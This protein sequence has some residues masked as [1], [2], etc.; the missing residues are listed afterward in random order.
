MTRIGEHQNYIWQKLKSASLPIV[1][2]GM[3]NGCDK[4]LKACKTHHI[5]VS[6]IFASDDFVRAQRFHDFTVKTYNELL[7]ELGDFIIIIAFS[8]F[9]PALLERIKSLCL[10]HEVYA[11]DFSVFSDEYPTPSFMDENNLAISRAYSLLSDDRSRQIF[12]ILMKYK[13]TGKASLLFLCHDDAEAPFS[14]FMKLTENERYMD[15]GAYKGDTI[16]SFLRMTKGSFNVIHAFEPDPKNYAG[17][18]KY[19]EELEYKNVFIHECAVSDHSGKT[20]FQG[21]GGRA[22]H[23]SSEGYPV[24]CLRLDDMPELN[25][26]FIKMDVEGA[27]AK[28][29]LGATQTIARYRPKMQISLYHNIGDFFSLP[30][31]INDIY[32][33]YKY[34]IRMNP[35][36]PAWDVMLYVTEE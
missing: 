23:M 16:D 20:C 28:A 1:I 29:L 15:L 18:K 2:Y 25:P 26:T 22:S 9:S 36:I 32:G 27:E 11:P 19:S 5:S 21:L 13:L 10:R 33:G 7:S 3:G 31:L 12:S 35:Y 30:L 6:G 4:V 34:R 24:S 8:A 17:L 14:S